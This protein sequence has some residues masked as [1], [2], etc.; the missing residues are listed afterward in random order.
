[1]RGD[2]IKRNIGIIALS[3]SLCLVFTKA[4]FS[5]YETE[6]VM[7]SSGNIY[8]LQYASFINKDVMEENIKKLD[9]YITYEHDNKYYVHVG[10]YVNLDTARKMKKYFENENI[11]TYIKN[12][13]LGNDDLINQI[14]E[15]DKK[16]LDSDSNEEILVNNKKILDLLKNIVS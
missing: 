7:I 14:R 5:S 6:Q 15:I 9:D 12:D 8:L 10:A 3:I 1:M 2:I 16:I 4:L 11:Y 13:Y